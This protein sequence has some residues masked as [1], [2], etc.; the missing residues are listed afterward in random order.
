M[1]DGWR[2]E[3]GSGDGFGKDLKS[4]EGGGKTSAGRHRR[5]RD[6]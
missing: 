6:L 3:K 1:D 4:R 2:K 5:D